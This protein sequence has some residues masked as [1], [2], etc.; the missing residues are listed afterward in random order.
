MKKIIGFLLLVIFVGLF[1]VWLFRAPILSFYL[2]NKL[3]VP[4]SVGSISV[5]RTSMKI[6]N[7]KIKNP[8]GFKEKIAFSAKEI[9]VF[10]KWADLSKDPVVIDKININDNQLNIFCTNPVCTSNNW[11]EIVKRSQKKEEKKEKEVI[12]NVLTLDNLNITIN[13]MGLIPGAKKEKNIPHLE[14]TKVSSKKGFPTNE[15]IAAIFESSGLSDFVD[16]I[17]KNKSFIKK[18]I[19]KF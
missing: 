15:L 19:E 10:Y 16:E 14:F 18:L 9:N 6:K 13:D 7:F 1:S 4:V 3:K 11:T 12:V 5:S 8:T 2:S 17:L